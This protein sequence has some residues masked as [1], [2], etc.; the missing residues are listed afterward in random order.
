MNNENGWE[1]MFSAFDNMQFR[2][3]L[4]NKY[5]LYSGVLFSTEQLESQLVWTCR[6]DGFLVWGLYIVSDCGQ[7]GG[8]TLHFVVSMVYC[9]E[10]T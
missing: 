7:G 6:Q 5:I 4:H 9:W 1:I 8:D 10:A 3:R 2:L